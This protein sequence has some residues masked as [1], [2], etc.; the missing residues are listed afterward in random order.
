MVHC[1]NTLTINCKG[2]RL[3]ITYIIF[4]Y[5]RCPCTQHWNEAFGNSI[6]SIT[7]IIKKRLNCSI[8]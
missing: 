8:N 2:P 6:D 7:I 1:S 5:I 3:K 4:D